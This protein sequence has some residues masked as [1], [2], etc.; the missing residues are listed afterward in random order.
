[1]DDD[2]RQP[3]SKNP[4]PGYETPTQPSVG[5]S[6]HLVTG[7][8]KQDDI[9]PDSSE[10]HQVIVTSR[11]TIRSEIDE[12][13]DDNKAKKVKT[14]DAS[15]DAVMEDPSSSLEKVIVRF[16]GDDVFYS[17]DQV[18]P[19]V[20]GAKV[21][22]D[23]ELEDEELEDEELEDE[24]L[25]DEKES[26]LD[27]CALVKDDEFKGTDE[28]EIDTMFDWSDIYPLVRLVQLTVNDKVMLVDGKPYDY[29][30]EYDE[31]YQL[32]LKDFEFNNEMCNDPTMAKVYQN[33]FTGAVE[34]SGEKKQAIVRKIEEGLCQRKEIVIRQR[35]LVRRLHESGCMPIYQEAWT[36]ATVEL[37]RAI[38]ILSKWD[39]RWGRS[40]LKEL[41]TEE[42]I[43]ITPY[44]P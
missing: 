4:P 43:N 31:L 6:A 38:L 40:Y 19:I 16:E 10:N 11:G 15:S 17:E 1:M 32:Q 30:S 29:E 2:Q 23:E 26:K 44:K 24:E 28:Y 7:S 42:E 8:N 20:Y 39:S 22:Q 13:T 41:K 12:S 36:N 18:D 33:V 14:A 35:T 21:D 27:E 9:L 25:V 34:A 3:P 37:K 5:S